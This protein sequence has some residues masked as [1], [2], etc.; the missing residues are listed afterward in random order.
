MLHLVF[1]FVCVLLQFTVIKIVIYTLIL[2]VMN[3]NK[4][5]GSELRRGSGLGSGSNPNFVHHIVVN[6]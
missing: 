4:F 1:G 3:P 6:I 5:A 2:R